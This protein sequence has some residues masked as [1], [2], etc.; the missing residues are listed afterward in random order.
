MPEV[1]AMWMIQMDGHVP[2]GQKSPE[3]R[4]PQGQFQCDCLT[5]LLA[6]E[7]AHLEPREVQFLDNLRS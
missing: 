1:K 6:L 5:L 3:R 4:G 2:E 7:R